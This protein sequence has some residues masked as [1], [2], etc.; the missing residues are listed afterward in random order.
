MFN[1]NQFRAELKGGGARPNLFRVIASFPSYSGTLETSRKFQYM[2]RSTHLPP[3]MIGVIPT[4]FQ[5]RFLPVAG[6]RQFQP[7][8]FQVV[9]DT[10]FAIRDAFERWMNAIQEHESNMGLSAPADYMV[11]AEV[12]QLDRSGDVLKTYFMKGIWPSHVGQI[13]LSQEANDTIELFD[14]QMNITMWTS[15]T[16]S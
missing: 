8:N 1:I 4:P 14:V 9:N 5:G 15:N 13:E 7:W 6:D 11:D 10:D 3:S 16:T 12:H 2:V